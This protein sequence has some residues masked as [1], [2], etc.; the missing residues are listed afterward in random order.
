[1]NHIFMI[2]LGSYGSA[3]T[4]S[5]AQNSENIITTFSRDPKRSLDK[6]HYDLE[7]LH[8]VRH[9]KLSDLAN[10]LIGLRDCTIF[11]AL[12]SSA[13]EEFILTFNNELIRIK[14]NNARIVNLAKG[15]V[16]GRL[17]SELFENYLLSYSS[18]Y[19]PSFSSDFSGN[20]GLT[21]TSNSS[22]DTEAIKKIFDSTNIYLDFSYNQVESDYLAILKNLYAII[23]GIISTTENNFSTYNMLVTNLMK[24]Y[25]GILKT[26][27]KYP[28]IFC[29]AGIGDFLLTT[30]SSKSRNRV[31]GE[32]I[33]KG[34][35]DVP[36]GKNTIVYEG[37]KVLEFIQ[38]RFPQVS[39]AKQLKLLIANE[40]TVDDFIKAI[41]CMDIRG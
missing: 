11:L 40:I 28:N 12:P 10:S 13:I 16:K 18:L 41:K 9:R 38:E 19:G 17:I 37:L 29:Y 25:Q 6:S 39:S 21:Y 33:S 34:L 22:F 4:N 36:I 31:L 1:M 26:I 15:V 5:L 24:E 3:M 8:N 20:I 32:M 14:P 2:G 7:I 30:G 23:F 27:S 35:M